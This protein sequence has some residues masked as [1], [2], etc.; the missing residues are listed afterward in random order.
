MTKIPFSMP[1]IGKDEANA[2]YDVVMSTW[3]VQ[4]ENVAE[5]ERKF[6]KYVG[7]KYAIAVFNGTVALHLATIVANIKPHDEVIVPSF[8]FV[9]TVNA[10]LYQNAIPIFAE[11]ES[12]TFNISPDDIKKRITNNTKA[13][14]PVHYGGQAADM[15]TILE[16][17]DENDLVVIEDSA[18]AH[19]A[20]YNGKHAGTF[21]DMAIFSF[22]PI[23][24]M[25]TGEGGMITTNN[26]YYAEKLRM[27][28][29][30]GMDK[31]YHH[32]MLGY[33]YRMTE[34]QAAIGLVQLKRLEDII[35][36]KKNIASI[37][38]KHLEASSKIQVPYVSH[39]TTRHSYM[40]YTIKVPADMRDTLVTELNNNGIESRGT[41]FP[42]VH[43][44]PFLRDIL[45][46]TD[47]LLP[48]TEQIAKEV[49]SLPIFFTMSDD[50]VNYVVDNTLK[51]ISNME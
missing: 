44:Q 20:M 35:E 48:K 36:R 26:E 42:P 4:G 11:I 10:V 30:H 7:T 16:I 28:R 47:G 6:A 25:T 1:Y 22:T 29:N 32:L 50:D 40:L 33:N 9:S 37:Y 46:D 27:L 23:K 43:L 19:G 41:Y 2:V 31:P 51:I 5:F 38:N 21:G 34:M 39:F 45:G 49:I 15:D 12:N 8:T 3:L 17:A 18:E 13:V 14:I 24:N